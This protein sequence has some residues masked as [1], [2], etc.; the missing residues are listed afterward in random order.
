MET[1]NRERKKRG[2]RE[3][4]RERKRYIDKMGEKAQG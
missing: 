1:G 2:V 4:G 3:K